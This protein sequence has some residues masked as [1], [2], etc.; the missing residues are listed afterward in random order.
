MNTTILN[1]DGNILRLSAEF[2]PIIHIPKN[3][4]FR[5]EALARF[6]S[7]DG[8]LMSTQQTIDKIEK[9]NAIDKVTDFMFDVVCQ[10]IKNKKSLTISFNLSHLLFNNR[11][12]L[13]KLYQACIK[14]K[15]N[16]RNIEIEISEKTTQLQLIEGISFLNQAKTY[17]FMI[18]LDDFGAGCLQIESLSLFNFDTIKIDRSIIDGIGTEEVKSQKLKMLLNRLRPLGANII[19]EGVERATDLNRLNKYHPIGIQGYIFYRPLTYSQLRL[20]EGF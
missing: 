16:P 11:P 19:C 12:Y 13:D 6:Y 7:S 15:I 4:I 5:Y 8:L 17:G 1:I 18:S 3:K 14:H 9:Y 20:L 10:V 2:Q